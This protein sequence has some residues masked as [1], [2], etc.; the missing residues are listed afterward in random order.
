M[1]QNPDL[2][3][4][5]QYFW[6]NNGNLAFMIHLAIAITVNKV[7]TKY[8]RV[9]SYGNLLKLRIALVLENLIIVHIQIFLSPR[10]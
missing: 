6:C 5:L 8:L 10:Q 4:V 9:S 7:Q 2:V 3:M 1:E